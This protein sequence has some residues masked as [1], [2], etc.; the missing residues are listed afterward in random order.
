MAKDVKDLRQAW[1]TGDPKYDVKLDGMIARYGMDDKDVHRLEKMFS[2][3]KEQEFDPSIYM[4][5]H[6]PWEVQK[7]MLDKMT[8]EDR[9]NYLPHISKQKRKKYEA[10][11]AA[12]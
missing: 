8:K 2:S 5:Q 9:E 11:E 6:L 1:N 10:A 7:P 12:E 4:F 3:P